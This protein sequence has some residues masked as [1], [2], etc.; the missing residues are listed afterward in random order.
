MVY[1]VDEEPAIEDD[2]YL[3]IALRL[4]ARRDLT[5]A[6]GAMGMGLQ[7][8][9]ARFYLRRCT[10][11][12]RFTRLKGRP[13]ITNRGTLVIG[14]H[15]IIHSH[16][17]PVELAALPGAVLEIG[18]RT[19]INYGVSIAATSSIR[20]GPRCLLGSYVNVLDSDWHG[21]G[22]RRSRPPSRP[23]SIEENVW[24]GNRV[25]VLPGVT[26][27]HDA[28]VGAGAVVTA[29]IPPRSLAV[30]NPARVVKTF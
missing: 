30:G 1:P 13:S 17:V 22:D 12:G 19:F 15:V 6:R 14:A 23:V 16:I 25:I 9:A 5:V 3:T 27:G 4:L 21:I 18:E 24:L 8:L 26:I 28:V 29:D 10:S 2:S 7:A 11:V 20:I